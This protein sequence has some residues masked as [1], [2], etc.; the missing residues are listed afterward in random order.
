MY[1]LA[2][3]LHKMPEEIRFMPWSDFI[4]CLALLKI[5]QEEADGD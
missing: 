3:R 5:E 2:F 4:H 1:A